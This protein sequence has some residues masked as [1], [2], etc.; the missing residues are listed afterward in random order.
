MGA[1]PGFRL[2]HRSSGGAVGQAGAAALVR[3]LQRGR[4]GPRK[5]E[6]AGWLVGAPVLEQDVDAFLTGRAVGQ[7]Q[8]RL[9]LSVPVSNIAAILGRH[10]QKGVKGVK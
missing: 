1:S 6:R 3:E 2:R 8:R 4:R 5:A 7:S 9:A 10:K